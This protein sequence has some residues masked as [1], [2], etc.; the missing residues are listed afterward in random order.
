MG[1]QMSFGYILPKDFMYLGDFRSPIRDAF[2]LTASV[3]RPNWAATSA[4]GRFGKSRFSSFKSSFVH[5]PFTM[6]LLA[7]S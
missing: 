6:L 4:V 3:G 1:W 7:I 2:F 5:D